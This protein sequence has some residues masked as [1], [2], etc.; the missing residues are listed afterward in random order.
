MEKFK[1]SLPGYS[2]EDVNRFVDEVTKEYEELLNKLKESDA[3]NASLTQE[4][5]HYRQMES[6]LNRAILLAE[7]STQNIKKSA[8]DE[9]K[10]VIEDA[11]RNASRIVNNALERAERIEQESEELRRK[12]VVFKK[13]FRNL[14]ED[15][16]DEIDRF[17][18]TL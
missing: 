9:S 10:V 3:R 17:D 2:K 11:K 16:L 12:V 8:Y 1:T 5:E 4:L 6:T 18:D 15:N 7:E 14:V 13:R